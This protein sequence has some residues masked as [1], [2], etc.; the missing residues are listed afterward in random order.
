MAELSATCSVQLL[1]LEWVHCCS[2]PPLVSKAF[3]PPPGPLIGFRGFWQG[4]VAVH[5]KT[6]AVSHM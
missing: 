2:C 4:W 6:V 3:L 5:N 1:L